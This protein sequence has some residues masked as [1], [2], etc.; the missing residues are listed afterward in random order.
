MRHATFPQ[1]YETRVSQE[2]AANYHLET[3]AK[4]MAQSYFD[5]FTMSYQNPE[6][7]AM[8]RR[9][10]AGHRKDHDRAKAVLEYLGATQ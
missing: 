8:K 10:F 1:L 6:W 3:A 5:A 7:R 2:W 9:M 4:G